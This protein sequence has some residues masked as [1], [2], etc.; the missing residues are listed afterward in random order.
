MVLLEFSITPLGQG[1][2]VSEHV[3]RCSRIVEQSGLDHQLHAM[4]TIIEGELEQVF[5]VLRKCFEALAADCNRISCTAKF[6]YRHGQRGRIR[7]KVASVEERLRG[8]KEE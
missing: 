4:G 1:E 3:A 5:D 6:D 7:S 8:E 2:S